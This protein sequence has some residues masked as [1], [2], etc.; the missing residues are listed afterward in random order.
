MLQLANVG[1]F[2]LQVMALNLPVDVVFFLG[3]NTVISGS[4]EHLLSLSM[5]L[6][7]A[8]SIY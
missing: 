5:C 6:N 3:W 8:C 2:R 7:T 4:L 1:C